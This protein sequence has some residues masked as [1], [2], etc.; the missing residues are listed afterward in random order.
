MVGYSASSNAILCNSIVLEESIPTFDVT[1][2]LYH[3]M[4][5]LSN[6]NATRTKLVLCV[7]LIPDS[8]ETGMRQTV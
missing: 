2:S 7:L 6:E 1:S 8:I 4:L 3:S 5:V